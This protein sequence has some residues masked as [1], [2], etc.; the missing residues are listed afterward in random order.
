LAGW[1]IPSFRSQLDLVGF[2]GLQA[3]DGVGCQLGADIL[4]DSDGRSSVNVKKKLLFSSNLFFF[5]ANNKTMEQRDLKNV[6]SCL[7]TNIYC[8]LETFVANIIKLFRHNLHP[9]A[10]YFPMILTEFTLIAT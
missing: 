10:A 9:L 4:H 2:S 5:V 7:N 1:N 8:Y 6:N 3:K